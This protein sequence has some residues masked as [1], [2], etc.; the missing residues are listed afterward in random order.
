MRGRAHVAALG[1]LLAASPAAAAGFVDPLDQPAGPSALAARRPL[2]SVARAGERLVAVGERGLAVFSDDGGARWT[3]AAVPVS[4]DLTAVRFASPRLGWAVGHG[5]V[6]LATEDGGARWERRLDGRGLARLLDAWARDGAGRI[7]PAALAQARDLAA[8]G[9]D[10]P[11]LDV[12]MDQAGREGFAVGAFGLALAT[13]DG[14]RSWTP[15]LD[16]IE[17][18]RAL[19]LHALLEARGTLYLAGEQGLLLRLDRAAGR[20]RA[21]AIPYGGSLF[22]LASVGRALLAFGLRG[23][24][25]R[26]VDGGPWQA[27]EAGV[28][29]TLAGGTALPD[30]RL[31][32][33]AVSGELLVSA[34]GGATF[35]RVSARGAV[36]A[37]AFAVAPAG[38]GA[39][40]VAGAEG[41]R[42]VA[43]PRPREAP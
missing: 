40:A 29:A 9:P 23:T 17:N 34:D 26:S 35:E 8:R 41:V 10:Q 15:C 24:V 1:L 4:E 21:V 39:L 38:D 13:G 28:E 42:V 12:W 27:V 33:A 32:L 16:R 3:Q 6:V 30:G 37:P 36:L 18:P 25:L 14:G 31:A 2:L 5:G 11:L 19:H 43:L 7:A 22:G 20:F